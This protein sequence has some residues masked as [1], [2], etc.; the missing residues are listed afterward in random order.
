MKE[1]EFTKF[2]CRKPSDKY[3]KDVLKIEF[4]ESQKLFDKRFRQ[5]KRQ[6]KASKLAE[7]EN[8]ASSNS[9]EMWKKIN[10]LSEP[11]SSK[12]IMEIIRE[13]GKISS[14]VKDVLTR[15]YKDI[16]GLFAGAKESPELVFDEEFLSQIQ[17]LKSEFESIQGT[18]NEEAEE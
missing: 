15:W 1:R 5:Y 17:H 6:H 12:V 9:A 7:L 2:K 8:L 13:D 16:S 11:K 18:I 10:A 3:H 4:R 14:D